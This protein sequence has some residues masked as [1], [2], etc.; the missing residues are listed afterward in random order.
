MADGQ[1][2]PMTSSVEE[3][4]QWFL[5]QVDAAADDEDWA[6]SDGWVGKMVLTASNEGP[7][8][9][10]Y[11]IRDGKMHPSN[12]PGPYIATMTMSIDSFLDIVKAATRGQGERA[13][14]EK[15]AGRH[16][17]YQGGRWIVDSE[18]FRKVFRRLGAAYR[19]PVS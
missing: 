16:I 19:R 8:V 5:S 15:Y 13:F 1:S 3:L 7:R 12:S 9:Y 2:L 10:V 6:E 14:Q 4:V 17:V 11:E 18:R